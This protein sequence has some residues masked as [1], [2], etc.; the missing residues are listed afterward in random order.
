MDFQ[1]T[2][3]DATVAQACSLVARHH[4]DEAFLSIVAKSGPYNHTSDDG[5]AVAERIR[6]AGAAIAVTPYTAFL[7]WSKVIGYS[8]GKQIFVN[9]RKL[10]LPLHN[11]V[12]NIMHEA[13]HVLGY[14]HKGNRVTDYNK[15]TVPYR[16][17]KLFAEYVRDSIQPAQ[18]DTR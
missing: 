18:A 9:T 6:S 3:N 5:A 15:Q 12:S 11:R 8:T 14:K 7:P 2:V 1:N 16:V 17:G 10:D 13:M 4:R